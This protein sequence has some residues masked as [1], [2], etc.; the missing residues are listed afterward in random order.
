MRRLSHGWL[1]RWGCGG[2]LLGAVLATAGC[3]WDDGSSAGSGGA[4][5]QPIASATID[6][7]ATLADIVPGQGV[8]V[9]VEYAAGGRWKVRVAC[10]T[11]YSGEPCQFDVILSS[12]E[13]RAPRLKEAL[14]L[15]S[16]DQLITDPQEGIRLYSVTGS[17]LDGFDAVA[18][19]GA[20]QLLD[21]YLDG[22]PE[23]R[24]IYWVGDG[25]L[26]RGSP[27]NPLRLIPSS[28]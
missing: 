6:T 11:V 9:F 21:S 27:T 1:R 23:S 14:E 13:G 22:Q 15:E 8:G 4:T 24:F 16:N 26:H 2:V 7:D 19:A 3:V 18:P 10:D 5:S 17:D 20:S 12:D 28:P 25:A